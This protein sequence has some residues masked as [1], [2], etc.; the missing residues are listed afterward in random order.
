MPKQLTAEG[1]PVSRQSAAEPVA[2]R[3]APVGWNSMQVAA[4]STGGRVFQ[5]SNDIQ[6]AIRAAIDDSEVTYTLAFHP[7]GA[8]DSRFH[9]IEVRT[10]RKGVDVRYRKGYMALPEE[11]ESEQKRDREI[12]ALLESPLEGAGIG[13]MAG[14]GKAG[15]ARPGAL[16]LALYVEPG[17]IAMERNGDRWTGAADV[18]ISQRSPQGRELGISRQVVRLTFDPQRYEV[19]QAQGLSIDKTV[20]PAAGA[21][22]LRVVIY[23]CASGRAG[24]LTLPIAR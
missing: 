9:K 5:N 19:F 18:A 24:S 13:M 6:G 4:E 23:D 21:S 8:V 10:N 1:G 22:Y 20:E 7:G 3:L 17:E 16:S 11:P 14:I 2:V 12:Q 15:A